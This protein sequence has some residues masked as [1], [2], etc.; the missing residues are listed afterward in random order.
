MSKKTL[1]I[2]GVGWLG[3]ALVDTLQNTYTIKKSL[4][5]KGALQDKKF[6]TCDLLIVS[7]TPKVHYL[8]NL[9]T[10]LEN[11]SKNTLLILLSSTSVYSR[12]TGAQIQR[13]GEDLIKRRH[14][15]YLILRLGGLMG[16]DRVAG[17]YTQGKTVQN[18][19]FSNYIHRDDVVEIIQ[20]LLLKGVK[21]EIFNL[22]CPMHP[23]KK[24]VYEKNAQRFSLEKTTFLSNDIQGFKVS[25]SKLQQ[26]LDYTFKYKNP[27]DFHT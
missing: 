9:N 12:K 3:Q 6:Y 5:S 4:R 26:H 7:L 23:S 11:T 15:N 14:P 25:S 10:V 2:L 16:Y 27:L 18:D 22:V 19:T 8:K 20:D 24:K 21:K 17:K 13:L 1:S